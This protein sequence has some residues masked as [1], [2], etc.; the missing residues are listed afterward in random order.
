MRFLAI[1][2]TV[3]P[4]EPPAAEHVAAMGRLI[5]EMA[6]AGVPLTTGRCLPSAHGARV[7]RPTGEVAGEGESEP[8][9]LHGAPAFENA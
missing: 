9:R 6:R 2:T 8:R 4:D 1:Y 5:E 3:E 7:R